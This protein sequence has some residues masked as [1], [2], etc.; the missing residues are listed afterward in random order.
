MLERG[1]G[2]RGGRKVGIREAVRSPKI[3]DVRSWWLRVANDG[4]AL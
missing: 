3:L 2:K 4:G 1:H